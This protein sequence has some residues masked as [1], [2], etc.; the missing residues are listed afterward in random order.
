MHAEFCTWLVNKAII[1]H[2]HKHNIYG[3]TDGYQQPAVEAAGL[4]Y[5]MSMFTLQPSC[6]D[7]LAYGTDSI[8]TALYILTRYNKWCG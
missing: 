4:Y 7:L 6:I 1:A 3:E 5:D 2:W 8:L